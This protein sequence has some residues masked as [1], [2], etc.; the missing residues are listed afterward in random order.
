MIR[1]FRCLRW[2]RTLIRC[3]ALPDPAREWR[4]YACPD[5]VAAADA[6]ADVVLGTGDRALPRERVEGGGGFPRL[7]A[8]TDRQRRC[9]PHEH[10]NQLGLFAP[11]SAVAPVTR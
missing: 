2:A 3:T 8:H 11:A 7:A 6:V 4:V 10:R 5:H 9:G 1:C